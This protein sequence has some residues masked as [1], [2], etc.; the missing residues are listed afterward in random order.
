MTPKGIALEL[1]NLYTLSYGSNQ[2]WE[3]KSYAYKIL[4]IMA[5]MNNMSYK[6]YFEISKELEKL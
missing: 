1:I 4:H 5:L 3:A 6:E 2:K